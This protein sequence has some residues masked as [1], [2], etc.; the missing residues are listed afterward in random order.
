MSTA[1]WLGR[2]KFFNATGFLM[3]ASEKERLLQIFT[4]SEGEFFKLIFRDGSAYKIK[5]VSSMHVE[6]GGDIVADVV[7]TIKSA[8]EPPDRWTGAAMNFHLEEVARVENDSGCLFSAL[9]S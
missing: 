4:E 8:G 7:E 1:G 5:V 9:E 2:N 6:E 3:N